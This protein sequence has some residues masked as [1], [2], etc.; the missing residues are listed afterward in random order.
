MRLPFGESVERDRE[1][2]DLLAR[3]GRRRRGGLC[4]AERVGEVLELAGHAL[5]HRGQVALEALREAHRRR[6]SCRSNP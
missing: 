4:G 3:R 1:V 2:G 5:L 6:A